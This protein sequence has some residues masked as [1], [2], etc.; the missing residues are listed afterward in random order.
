MISSFSPVPGVCFS[1]TF[2]TS[3]SII[4]KKRMRT[5]SKLLFN[6]ESVACAAQVSLKTRNEK[7]LHS[8]MLTR[9]FIIKYCMQLCGLHFALPGSSQGMGFL[10]LENQFFRS[11]RGVLFVLT[12]SVMVT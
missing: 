9:S 7:S 12:V 1:T 3:L 8:V 2:V 6:S 5:E 11:L 10:P 4:V